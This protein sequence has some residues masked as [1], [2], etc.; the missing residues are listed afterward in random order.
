MA[1]DVEVRSLKELLM[2]KALK[3]LQISTSTKTLYV[4]FN[5]FKGHIILEGGLYVFCEVLTL[6][7]SICYIVCQVLCLHTFLV[8]HGK[9][10]KAM[11]L[12]MGKKK[13]ELHFNRS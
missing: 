5:V 11:V 9:K 10:Y 4:F 6:C 12:Y 1:C 2:L 13:M 3:K 7:K 8:A